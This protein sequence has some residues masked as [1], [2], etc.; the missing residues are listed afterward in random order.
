[1]PDVKKKQ[2]MSNASSNHLLD[3]IR[4]LLKR[5]R[6]EREILTILRSESFPYPGLTLEPDKIYRL[7]TRQTI[8]DWSKK[9]FSEEQIYDGSVFLNKVT[10]NASHFQGYTSFEKVIFCEDVDFTEV[11]FDKKVV[12]NEVIFCK[13]VDFSEATF[14]EQALFEEVIFAGEANYHAAHFAGPTAFDR[15]IWLKYLPNFTNAS[16]VEPPDPE[17]FI[18]ILYCLREIDKPLLPERCQ[19]Q[20]K[21]WI[22]DSFMKEKDNE[23]CYGKIKRLFFPKCLQKQMKAWNPDIFRTHEDDK[24]FYDKIRKLRGFAKTAGDRKSEL[25]YFAWQIK[26][27]KE[28]TRWTKKITY[29]L[30]EWFS[31]YGRSALRPFLGLLVVIFVNAY[32]HCAVPCGPCIETSFEENHSS[33]CKDRDKDGEF[34]HALSH[35]LAVSI[36]VLADSYTGSSARKD[37]DIA[38]YVSDIFSSIA[39]MTFLFLIALAWRNRFRL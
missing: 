13:K 21:I 27:T 22:A 30:Y 12:F 5:A 17:D 24:S 20:T 11:T 32:I 8:L 36:P 16:F 7:Q 15:S 23:S 1:M 31:D 38:L 2:I 6:R 25:D 10:F 19:E 14:H 35:V 29:Y 3:V 28:K 34:F 39:S 18:N 26:A 9:A 33:L 37:Y 4:A